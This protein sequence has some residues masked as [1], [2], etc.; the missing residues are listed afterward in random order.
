MAAKKPSAKATKAKQPV[1]KKAASVTEPAKESAKK[2]APASKAQASSDGPLTFRVPFPA[3]G[4]MTLTASGKNVSLGAFVPATSP[5]R[6]ASFPAGSRVH[7]AS[8]LGA[9]T[10]SD[11]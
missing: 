8:V 5:G 3:E 1:V 11:L 2:A 10:V 6:P 4:E 7:G 9:A